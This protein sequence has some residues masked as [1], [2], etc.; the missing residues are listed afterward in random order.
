VE[1]FWGLLAVFLVHVCGI[2]GRKNA[3]QIAQKIAQKISFK[4]IDENA[5]KM[6][7]N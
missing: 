5:P 7:E 4:K 2:F 6:N 1:P 3:T